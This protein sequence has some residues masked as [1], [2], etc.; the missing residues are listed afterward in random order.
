MLGV[1]LISSVISDFIGSIWHN[2]SKNGD[3][4]W[5]PSFLPQMSVL[6]VHLYQSCVC[7]VT[8]LWTVGLR[9]RLSSTHSVVKDDL[10]YVV[11]SCLVTYRLQSRSVCQM[12]LQM[13]VLAIK[14]CERGMSLSLYA[15]PCFTHGP[16]AVR[17]YPNRFETQKH[18]DAVLPLVWGYNAGIRR[19][20]AHD[21]W[22]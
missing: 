2:S 14:P 18:G 10:A 22:W 7:S 21:W 1:V 20:L 12:W 6:V 3:G 8:G 19:S 4:L 17:M 16:A 9:L 5:I 11:M 13:A 15:C